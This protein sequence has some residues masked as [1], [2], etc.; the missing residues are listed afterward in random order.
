MTIDTSCEHELPLFPLNTV[1]FPTTLLPL[2]IFEPRYVDLVGRCM[3]DNSGFGVIAIMAGAETGAPARTHA[4]GTVARIVD[5]D[6]DDHG[7]LN[8]VIRGDERFRVRD[9]SVQTDK[10]LVGRVILLN[11]LDALP[12]PEAFQYLARL[13]EEI[14]SNAEVAELPGPTPTT[15]AELAYGLAQYLPLNVPAK[16]AL[17]E[18]D[19][20]GDLLKRLSH[21]VRRLGQMAAQ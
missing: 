6:Q 8:I 16:L 21:D 12:I 19:N 9:T 17:L 4:T 3:R 15:A 20:P 14:V 5:F 2:R 18:I 10:L 13:L 11:E 1:L 7:L